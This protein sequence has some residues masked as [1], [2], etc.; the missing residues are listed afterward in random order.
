MLAMR[1]AVGV[2]R[3]TGPALSNFVPEKRGWP[4]DIGVVAV[5]DGAGLFDGAGR[6]R[7]NRVRDRIAGRLDLAPRL[8]Q[9]VYR[10]PPGLGRPLWVDAPSFNIADHIHVHPLPTPAGETELLQACEELRRRS[11]DPSRPLWQLW[12]LPGLP[13]GQVGMFIKLHHAIADGVAG[14]ALLGNLLDHAADAAPPAAPPWTPRPAPAARDLLLDNLRRYADALARSTSHLNHPAGAT[15]RVRR[16]WGSVRELLTEPRAPRTSLNRPIGATR[17]IA[18]VHCHLD[19]V[20]E[21]AHHADASVNDAVLAAVAGGLRDL[22]QSRR[23]NVTGL[24]L[25]AM[26]PVALHDPS[27]GPAQGN[28]YGVMVVSLPIGEPN[29]TRRLQTI[30]A[31]T[32]RRK[33][34][35]RRPWGTGLLGSPLVQRL[36]IRLADRQH[37]I[38]IHVAN[39][40]GPAT[41]L[42]LAGARLTEAFPVT[43]LSGNVTLGVGVLSYTDQL[44]ISVIADRDACPD[45]P[46]FTTGLTNCLSELTGA[47]VAGTP[48]SIRGTGPV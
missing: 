11:L 5:L 33:H 32:T 38:N 27:L 26:V 21:A 7:I 1:S 18:V 2:D 15:G 25:H 48:A 23:E 22:L 29:A 43:P 41:P 34:Q 31:Q 4:A 17:R 28:R 3:L 30:A 6:L 10:P 40:P 46:T 13:D 14:V 20:H 37:F 45:L 44:N 24:V 42:Y 36:A 35:P 9:V 16:T 8:R 19:A 12:L 39:V 47:T